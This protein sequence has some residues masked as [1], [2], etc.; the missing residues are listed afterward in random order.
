MSVQYETN[1][2]YTSRVFNCGVQ[3]NVFGKIVFIRVSLEARWLFYILHDLAYK[4]LC[5]L[6]T[7]CTYVFG[8]IF[9][10]RNHDA[11]PN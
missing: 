2:L 11:V 10:I 8:I 4:K 5:I 9:K 1:Q 6:T 3:W 7:V